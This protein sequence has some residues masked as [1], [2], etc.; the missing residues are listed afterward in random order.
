MWRL[1]G[2]QARLDDPRQQATLQLDEPYHGLRDWT[3][4]D[5]PL[6][7]R[8]LSLHY[9]QETQPF[10]W[11]VTEAY[12]RGRDL[13]ATYGATMSRPYSLQVYW[14]VVEPLGAGAAVEVVVSVQT[15]FLETHPGFSLASEL[16]TAEGQRDFSPAE[17]VVLLHASEA[18]SVAELS[19]PSDFQVGETIEQ[20][21]GGIATCWQLAP[22]FLEKGV[23]RRVRVRTLALPRLGDANAA[24]D[25]YEAI[26]S[27]RPPL[28]T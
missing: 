17:G 3:V 27:E 11:P 10:D 20:A 23:I 18:W 26:C 2:N 1:D 19:P 24:R 22:D 4:D 13:V 12:V 7:A 6:A 8:L 28:T 5:Q 9:E 15:E 16:P 25:A 14:R 21:T